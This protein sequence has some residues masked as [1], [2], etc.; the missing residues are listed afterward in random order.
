MQTAKQVSIRLVN[1][2][3]RLSSVLSSMTKSKVDLLAL[4]VMD[5]GDRSKLR[6]VPDDPEATCEALDAMNIK[7]E[8]A[9]V[10]L[11]E[12]SN[13]NPSFQKLCERLASEHLNVDYAYGSVSARGPKGGAIA[14]IKVNDLAKAQ[15]VLASPATN[16]RGRPKPVRRRPAQAR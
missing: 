8:L 10:L 2:P 14:V 16:G 11:A 4:T 5:S 13:R 3:G 1:K 12:V 9:D 7:Y 6:F 15:R